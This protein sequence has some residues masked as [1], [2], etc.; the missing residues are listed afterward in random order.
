MKRLVETIISRI[1]GEPYRLD[2]AIG[3]TDLLN[4]LRDKGVQVVRGTW[5]SLFFGE[6]HGLV[7]SGKSVTIRHAHSI[8]TQGG[9]T[10]GDG[11]FIN[12]LSKDGITLGNN[13]SIGAGSVI[14]CTGVIRELGDGIV[15]GNHVGFAQ[16]AFIAVRGPIEIG[17]DCIFGP[18]VAI[19]SENHIYSNPNI[20][21]R[22]Q[23][24]T[25]MGVR[26]GND[27]WIG[28]GAVILDGVTIGSGCIIAAGA[29]VTKD[30]PANS[31]VG[32]VPAKLIGRRE[33]KT[34]A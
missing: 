15:I 26:I 19:H 27:C 17:N 6:R 31:V 8:R 28:E 12:A 29:V 34:N 21:I 24:A 20:P 4:I 9:L 7:F 25:R 3:L 30:V 1:K 10:I 18:N 33:S 11:V 16:N 22:Q 13:V 2:E 32:G 23:G 5:K 14:E